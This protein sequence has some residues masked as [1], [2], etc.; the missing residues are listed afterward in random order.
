MTEP[1]EFIFIDTDGFNWLLEDEIFAEQF[2]NRMEKL[3]LKGFHAKIV[4]HYSDNKEKFNRLFYACGTLIF[5]SNLDWYFY[6]NYDE[7]TM[8]FSF[9][10]INHAVS[11]LSLSTNDANSTTMV[12]T[13]NSL[14]IK[15]KL[16]AEHI[17]SCSNSIF[18][19]YELFDMIDIAKDITMFRNKGA[20]YSFLPVP[21]FISVNEKILKEILGNH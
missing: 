7:A 12:F 11:I 18:I 19:Y 6:E 15:H 4:L 17:V 10:I 2:T 14:V 5:N 13:D 3:L 9:F 20:M 8:Y 21:A 16:L 1:G